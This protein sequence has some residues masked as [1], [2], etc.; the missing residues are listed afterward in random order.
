MMTA[1]DPDAAT[2]DRL[3]DEYGTQWRIRRTPRLWI[4]TALIPDV[5][6]TL[7][8]D[9]PEGLEER[10]RNPDSRI[11]GPLIPEPR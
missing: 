11:G 5:E 2:L 1:V 6:P 3:Q 9:T 8:E 10:M 4:A 7:I